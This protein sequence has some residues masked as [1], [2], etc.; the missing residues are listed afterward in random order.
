MNKPKRFYLEGSFG[1]IHCRGVF[2]SQAKKSGI[3]CCHMSPKSGKSFEDILPHLAKDRFAV[4]LDYPGYGESD[5]PPE[6]P[7]VTVED[8]ASAVWEVV[9]GLTAETVHLM[10]YHTGSMVSVE[11]AAQRRTQVKSIINISA[12][13]FTDEEQQQLHQ[14][15]SP[16]PLDEEGTRF[17]IMWER[18]MY[19]RGPGMTLEMA[20]ASYAENFRGGENY[21]FGHRAAFNYANTYAKRLGAETLPILVMNPK[22][23]CYEQSRRA[24]ELLQNG[25]RVDYPQWGHGFLSANAAEAAK[26]VLNFLEEND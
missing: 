16:I 22:D 24:D 12:P 1:Q 11:A 9:D 19:H 6:H 18:V 2:P 21:E 3:V 5:P 10:G 23:D 25:K 7:H 14:E 26:E 13:I 8:Y 20:A 4:A 15:Y 17:K